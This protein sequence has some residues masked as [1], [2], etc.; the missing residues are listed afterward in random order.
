[1]K[2]M[3]GTN[4]LTEAYL[5]DKTARKEKIVIG[6]S[7]G[8]DSFVTAYLL[9]IQRYELVAVTIAP[10]FP[11]MADEQ[12]LISC[13]LPDSKIEALQA[14]CHQLGIPH[15]VVRIPREFREVVVERWMA[16]KVSGQHMDQCWNCHELRMSFLHEKMKELG[17]K[18]FATGHY[19]K[20]FRNEGDGNNFVQTSNDE[21]HDQS[22]LLSR[23]PQEILKDLMLPLSDLQKK[24]V[25]KLA[26]NFGVADAAKKISMHQCF[27]DQ[28]QTL[29]FLEKKIPERFRKE[30]QIVSEDDVLTDHPGVI[31]YRFGSKV[32]ETPDRKPLFFSRY[33]FH[34]RKIVVAGDSWFSRE[35]FILRNCRIPEETPWRIP[36]R[37][38]IL[39]EGKFVEGWFY[40]KTLNT[41]L[42]ELDGPGEFRDGDI[43][44]VQKKRG[45]N[46][47][48]L[49]TGA[50]SFIEE[51]TEGDENVIKVDYSRDF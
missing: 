46:S 42:V 23:L 18:T 31:H 13:S 43:V 40:P 36:F 25:L 20:I 7:G 37:G 49:L 34:E 3:N 12:N 28:E 2:E 16:R 29:S 33:R 15:F 45:K 4:K 50:V 48:M 39:L 41:C 6:L 27:A 35:K 24:E 17:A 8:I 1:M 22:Q 10:S 21:Q 11:E 9:K 30:G 38:A 26:E 47:R 44:G 19:A 51:K 5:P 32:T 14:F